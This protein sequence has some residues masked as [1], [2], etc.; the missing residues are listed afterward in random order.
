MGEAQFYK[1]D[2]EYHFE[3]KNGQR[4]E[5]NVQHCELPKMCCTIGHTNDIPI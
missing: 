4:S 5:R 3:M 1:T 2:D